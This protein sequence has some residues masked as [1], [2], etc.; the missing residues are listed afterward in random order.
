MRR[1][2]QPFIDELNSRDIVQVLELEK[3]RK[4]GREGYI[5]P[6]CKSGTGP[7]GTGG[8]VTRDH[9]R[10]TCWD[11]GCELNGNGHGQDIYGAL[12]AITG[13]SGNEILKEYFP[14]YDIKAALTGT[15]AARTPTEPPKVPERKMDTTGDAQPAEA[16]RADY[17]AYYRLCRSRLTDPAARQYLAFRGISPETAAA[18]FIGFDPAADPANVPGA[19]GDEYKPHPC[20]RLII[21]FDKGHYMGRSIDPATGK[22][23][24]KMNSPRLEGDETGVQ[25]FNLKA[26]EN[27]DGRPVF[28]CEG[29]IDALSVIEAGGLAVG[30]N[31]ASNASKLLECLDRLKGHQE[32]PTMI[33]CLDVDGAGEGGTDK[34]IE[35]LTER[36]ISF[37]R[38]QITGGHKDPNEALTADRAAF[39]ESVKSAERQTYKPDNVADFVNQRMALEIQKF[40][41]D[42]ERSTGFKNLDEATGGG[43]YAGLYAVGGIS[44]VGKTSF[45]TQLAEQLA[46]RGQHVLFFSMEQSRLEIVSKGIARRTAIKNPREGVTSL[47]IRKGYLPGNA[48]DA[49]DDYIKAVGERFSVIEGNFSCTVSLIREYATAYMK[50]NG[51]R[52]V[53]IIDYLQTLKADVDP[54]T[55]RKPTDTRQIVESNVIELKRI[56]RSLET[57]VFV[58]SS[59]N[60][61]N[62]LV[63]IDFE[64]FKESGGIE[65][66]AD[67]VWGLQLAVINDDLFNKEGKIKEKREKIKEAKAASP[68]QIELVCLKNRYG[69]SSYT[70]EFTY[71]PQF[72]LFKEAPGQT[73]AGR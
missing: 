60:R 13:K 46:E 19:M 28:V 34:L 36:N 40:R 56:S 15:G 57:P 6:K 51:V 68:R 17:T 42:A 25:P 4:G 16:A 8:T 30:L 35:G 27:S 9:R 20:P 33:L 23:Y 1:Y 41:A 38:G 18:Y 72:D 11:P 12:Q 73:G 7:N 62:Y 58:I 53:I 26:L 47:S 54:D 31:S 66:T 43:I 61:S 55:K 39:I 45:I 48:L 3:D 21:P 71:Y 2:K 44:S 5:C 59:V 22:R 24:L 52:P 37:T 49:A 65:F 10:F 14:S 32:R 64:A 29:A 70:A 67:V 63:P 69:V 50:R